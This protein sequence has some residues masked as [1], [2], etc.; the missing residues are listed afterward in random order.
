MIPS[1]PPP[2]PEDKLPEDQLPED[3]LPEDDRPLES[4]LEEGLRRT[5]LGDAAYARMREAVA[6]EW[7]EA[8]RPPSRRPLFWS[9]IAASLVI[10]SV[11]AVGLLHP[12][13]KLPVIGVVARTGS[14]PLISPRALLLPDQ[15]REAGS[16]FRTGDVLLARGPALVELAG[17]GTLRMAGGA[18]VKAL[19][20][21]QI[22][23]EAGEVYVDLPPEVPSASGFLVRTPLGSVEH[24]GT[25]FDVAIG[26][27]LRIR[28]REGSVRLRRGATT[29][30]A[31]AGTELVVPPTGPTTVLPISTHGSEWSWIEALEPDYIIENRSLI[32]FLQWAARE[33]GRR[34]SFGDDRARETAERTHLHGSITGMPA[35]QAL[36]TILATT[37]LRYDLEGD[38][39]RV[40]SQR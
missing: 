5:P 20:P 34:L 15:Q 31:A 33:T 9:A 10:A 17:G 25:Q 6:A 18:R 32:E 35:F 23:L 13:T 7:R 14:G 2:L 21:G 3:Q 29:E 27:D 4:I 38:L 37:S 16:P 24:L 36:Q 30:T 40:S 26:R 11:F 8:V 28:V 39:I 22:M 12:F 19:A 1:E